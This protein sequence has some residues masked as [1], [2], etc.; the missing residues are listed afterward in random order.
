MCICYKKKAN[1][2]YSSEPGA[3]QLSSCPG[4]NPLIPTFNMIFGQIFSFIGL[5]DLASEQPE[6]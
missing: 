6:Y 5:S 4:T 3:T 1:W 2:G